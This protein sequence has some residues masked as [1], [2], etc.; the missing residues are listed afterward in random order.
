MPYTFNGFGTKYYG[1][2][3]AAE[4]GS[5][6]TTMWITALYVP[7]LP[8]GSYLGCFLL[9]RAL[10]GSSTVL[11][12]IRRCPYRCAGSRCGTFT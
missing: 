6:V 2:R 5:Y 3:E 7:I 1:R 12:V 11:R 8:L 9:V 4:D 10:I